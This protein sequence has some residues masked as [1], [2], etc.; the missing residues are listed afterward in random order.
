MSQSTRSA[1]GLLSLLFHGQKAIDAVVASLEIG[2]LD[3]LDAGPVTLGAMA[4]KTG[5]VPGRLYKLLDCLES[6][7]L[8]R[9]RRSGDAITDTIYEAVEPLKQAALAVVGPESIERD[10]DKYGWRDIYGH[11]PAVL[12]GERS[13]SRETFDWPPR[14]AD[15]VASFEAS[16]AAGCA[17]IIEAF[18]GAA[19]ALWG[20]RSSVRL[21]DVGGGDGLLAAR[22]LS[23]DPRLCADVYNLAA[24]RPLVEQR[25]LEPG[26]AGRLGFV[27]GDFCA[28]PLPTGY[29][30]IS[31]VRVLHD[32][33]DET[34][35]MLLEKA[36]AALPSGGRVIV[37]EEFR[38]PDRLAIQ[39]FWSYFLIGVDSCVSR[40]R[41][42][43]LYL[44]ALR[45]IGFRDDKVIHGGFDIITA[46]RP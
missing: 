10:R 1:R 35:R 18:L 43:D 31:F 33:P 30:A 29:D 36:Y 32:W 28:Q 27:A 37:C 6:L 15:Q 9:R 21:L 13:T 38:T 2:L 41:E 16:M 3:L 5:A 39:F 26:M 34:A 20:D 46:T 44:D 17:P 19:S 12:R 45:A 14:S 25:M 40:L 22:L 23:S 7:G 24:V 8:V 42:A 11:L 4:A